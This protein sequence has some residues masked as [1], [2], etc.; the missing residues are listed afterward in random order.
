MKKLALVL[1]SALAMA[2]ANAALDPSVATNVGVAQTD[3]IAL[4]T[5]LTGAGIAI[6]VVSLV[7]GKF[8]IGK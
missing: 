2:Q 3:M 5:L 8:R 7:Y 1:G 6:W 4:Y